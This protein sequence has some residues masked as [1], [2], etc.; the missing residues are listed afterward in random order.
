M[1]DL[2]HCTINKGAYLYMKKT[3]I[4]GETEELLEVSPESKSPKKKVT[5]SSLIDENINF[6]IVGIGASAGGLS[7]FESFFSGLPLDRDPNIAI[8]LIQHLAPHHKSILTDIIKRYTR[9]HV[10]EVEDG[11]KVLPNCVY[12]IP[13]NNDMAYI[14]G[15]LQLFEQGAHKG[16]NMPIDFFFRSLAEDQREKSICVI[17]SGTGSDGT[18]GLRSI[19]AEGGLVLAQSPETAEY[20]GMPL[21]AIGTGLVDYK[22]QASEMPKRIMMYLDHTHSYEV[23]KN[24][25]VLKEDNALKKVF[26]LLRSQMGHDFSKYKSNTINRRIARRLAVNQIE[27]MDDYVQYLQ[28]N[29]TEVELLFRDLLIGVTM[30]FRDHELFSILEENIIP[31]LFENKPQGSVIRVWCAGCST[32][33]E[34]YSFAILLQ[35]KVEQLKKNYRIQ[36]FATDID[37]RAIAIARA[38]IYT[39][40][41]AQDVSEERLA[42]FFSLRTESDTYRINK[43]IRDLLVFSEQSVIKDPPFSRLDFIACRNLMIYFNRELQTKLIPTFHYALNPGAY[44]FLGNSETIGD[45]DALFTVYDRKSK[46]FRKKEGI[47]KHPLSPYIILPNETDYKMKLQNTKIDTVQKHSL[48]DMTEQSILKESSVVGILINEHGDILYLHGK[49][50]LYLELNPGESGVNNVLKMARE[51]LK[52]ELINALRKVIERRETVRI[53]RISIKNNGHIS[54]VNLIVRALTSG[55]ASANETPLYIILLDVAVELENGAQIVTVKSDF[56]PKVNIELEELKAE[57]RIKDEYLQT[58]IEE[59]ETSNEELK[60]SN[61]ELQSVN[62]ELQSTNEELETSKEELQSINEELSTVN[63]ELQIKVHDLSQVNNDMNNLLA[64]TNIA[65]VF[66][67]L[68][69]KVLRFT[70]EANKIVNLISTDI[71]RPF[72][73]IVTNIVNYNQ[74]I[75]DVKNVLDTLI[76]KRIDVLTVDGKWFNMILQPYRTIDNVIEGTV[77][78]FVDI[79]DA[80]MAKEALAVSELSYRTMFEISY[81]GIVILDGQ[82]GKVLKLNPAITTMLGYLEDELLEKEIWNNDQFKKFIPSKERLTDFR[83]QKHYRFENVLLKTTFGKNIKVE[84]ICSYFEISGKE[85]IQ[86]NIRDFSDHLNDEKS[87][88]KAQL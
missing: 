71:G 79:S 70:P 60:S 11:M 14:N 84:I 15:Y 24:I 42:R 17:L 73:H 49:S 7:A 74:L 78:T 39:R 62:E 53:D 85:F 4:K 63:S 51:G 80:K 32:G 13:P 72:S 25:N 21:S 52:F 46:I 69:Q 66:L 19:K 56:S 9:M 27:T 6:P 38:G 88:T 20:D 44:L 65:T 45:F 68:K 18:L 41:I 47:V 1:I 64:G 40:S 67:D 34:A 59:L 55:V 28:K 48:K 29:P 54:H 26:I 37:N 12:I 87:Q 35:E 8:V 86:C 23:S 30:F 57:L 82:T 36:I 10:Y 22:L 43:N 3:K 83:E 2:S 61:E 77:I 5:V 33:E 16:I 31:K 75:I 76:P 50:G 58:S 81:E